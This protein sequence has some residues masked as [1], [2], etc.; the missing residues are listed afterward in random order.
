MDEMAA[1][2][3]LIDGRYGSPS[4][5]DFSNGVAVVASHEEPVPNRCQA[6]RTAAG[7][8]PDF[9]HLAID[10]TQYARRSIIHEIEDAADENRAFRKSQASRG[11]FDG[12][13]R[14]AVR[15]RCAEQQQSG[16]RKDYGAPD[17]HGHE[18]PPL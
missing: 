7:L 17:W 18:T 13:P 3:V 4:G 1:R 11:D 8:V 15:W 9:L 5:R 14:L 10:E 12:A 2:P 6:V 16:H